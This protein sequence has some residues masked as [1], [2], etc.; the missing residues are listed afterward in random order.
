MILFNSY[1]YLQIQYPMF[2]TVSLDKIQDYYSGNVGDRFK[3]IV[4]KF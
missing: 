4:K 3:D 2:L 1:H